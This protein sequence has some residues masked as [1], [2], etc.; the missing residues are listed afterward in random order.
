MALRTALLAFVGTLVACGGPPAPVTPNESS[1]A[2]KQA[3][4]EAPMDRDAIVAAVVK[5]RGLPLKRLIEFRV[6]S[7]D[8]FMTHGRAQI[9]RHNKLRGTTDIAP[10]GAANPTYYL[11][12]LDPGSMPGSLPGTVPS[13]SSG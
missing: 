12:Y 7:D 11:A 6:V 4:H 10:S 13:T 3:A 8:E 2:S 9:E 1:P 5:V